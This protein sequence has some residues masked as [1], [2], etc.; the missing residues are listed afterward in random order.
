MKYFIE[1][2]PSSSFHYFLHDRLDFVLKSPSEAAATADR[3]NGPVP[4]NPHRGRLRKKL[5]PPSILLPRRHHWRSSRPY[6]R[7]R[8][9][10]GRSC[11][12]AAVAPS[13]D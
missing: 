5:S 6:L 3:R 11:A 2:S 7:S 13:A 8:L 10:T 4:A 9:R 12:R 1:L